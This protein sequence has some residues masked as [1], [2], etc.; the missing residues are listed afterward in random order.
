MG[1]D[2]LWLAAMARQKAG[3]ERNPGVMRRGLNEDV[4]IEARS[5]Q[6]AVDRAIQRN[7]PSQ[8]QGRRI[9]QSFEF[10]CQPMN[11]FLKGELH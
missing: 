8:Y 7:A 3:T 10:S 5:G 1:V 9:C 6:V 4:L 11:N 2:T